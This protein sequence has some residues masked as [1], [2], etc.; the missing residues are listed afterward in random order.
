MKNLISNNKNIYSSIY[1]KAFTIEKYK[2]NDLQLFAFEG[3]IKMN[4]TNQLLQ[5]IR[6][7]VGTCKTQIIKTI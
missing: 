4:S 5:Y 6:G 2:L 7:V 3:F 1:L